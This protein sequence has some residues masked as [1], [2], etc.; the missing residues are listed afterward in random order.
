MHLIEPSK[1]SAAN[2]DDDHG[3]GEDN[4]QQKLS[5]LWEAVEN[6]KRRQDKMVLS[7]GVGG[8]SLAKRYILL[9]MRHKRLHQM[10]VPYQTK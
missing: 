9:S 1:R 8:V 4:T 5:G 10:I 6:I 7:I 2:G 3:G